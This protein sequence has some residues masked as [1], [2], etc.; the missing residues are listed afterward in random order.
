MAYDEMLCQVFAGPEV[1]LPEGHVAL[2]PK[3][4]DLYDLASGTKASEAAVL[5]AARNAV[6]SMTLEQSNVFVERVKAVLPLRG[7]M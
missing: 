7:L 6:G 1:S 3:K 2:D 4:A 5:D